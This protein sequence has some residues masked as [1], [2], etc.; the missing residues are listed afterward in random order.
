MT[1]DKSAHPPT[2]SVIST[3]VGRRFFPPSLPRRCRPTQWRNLSSIDRVS[4]PSYNATVTTQ[5]L[6]RRKFAISVVLKRPFFN[7]F[8]TLA[9]FAQFP[10]N[11]LSCYQQLTAS[12]CALFVTFCASNPLFSTS[13]GLFWQ[14]HRGVG[15]VRALKKTRGVAAPIQCATA[16]SV[17]KSALAPFQTICTPMHTNRNEVNCRI[18][19]MPVV[20]STRPS[21]SA[22]L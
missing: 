19:V 20:P 12:F 6:K 22:K 2:G 10:A 21:R 11:A 5:L 7:T 13:C 3:G 16:G 4:P 17:A 8:Q 18:T 15:G 1:L 14:K 9:S